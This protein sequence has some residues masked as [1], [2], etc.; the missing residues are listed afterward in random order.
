MT[1]PLHPN[2]LDTIKRSNLWE[3]AV[4]GLLNKIGFRK[5]G[6]KDE[7]DVQRSIRVSVGPP[8]PPDVGTMSDN[9]LPDNA[10][11]EIWRSDVVKNEGEVSSLSSLGSDLTPTLVYAMKCELCDNAEGYQDVLAIP[12]RVCG[13]YSSSLTH[14]KEMRLASVQ[15]NARHIV[16]AP[17]RV[18]EY[19]CPKV[20][21]HCSYASL[22]V[23]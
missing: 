11:K 15:L 17:D 2:Q 10:F 1:N 8:V 13:F 12:I 23:T 16:Q 4:I 18:L 20:S 6:R 3:G 14:Q 9:I 21:K 22:R 19:S 5:N 7:R